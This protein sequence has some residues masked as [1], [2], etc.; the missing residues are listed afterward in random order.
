[1][2]NVLILLYVTTM[3]II[4][5]SEE[6]RSWHMGGTFSISDLLEDN[7]Y[8]PQAITKLKIKD[9]YSLVLQVGQRGCAMK[10]SKRLKFNWI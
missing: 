9:R 3:I 2:V 10:H 5:I 1:M 4:V 8:D 7:I 6:L